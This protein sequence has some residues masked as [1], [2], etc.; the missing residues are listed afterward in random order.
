MLVWIADI[1]NHCLPNY[2]PSPKSQSPQLVFSIQGMTCGGCVSKLKRELSSLEKVE[3]VQVTLKPGQATVHGNA[4][5]EDVLQKIQDLGF[6]GLF[7][8]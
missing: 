3:Q 1:T 2:L 4:S 5:K 6:T 8:S 7:V